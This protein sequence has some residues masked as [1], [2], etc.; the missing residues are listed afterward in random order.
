MSDTTTPHEL[1]AETLRT[2]LDAAGSP[3]YETW[4]AMTRSAGFCTHPIRLTRTGAEGHTTVFARCENRRANVCPSCSDLYAADTW[5]LVAG[6]LDDDHLNGSAAVFATL[7]APS[8]GTVHTLRADE[9]GTPRPCHSHL[10]RATVCP[11]GRPQHCTLTHRPGDLTLGRPLCP[12]CYDYASHALTTW[13][14]PQL[15]HR[16]T[17][18]LRRQIRA[19]H[20]AVRVS[21]VK[22]M[23]LQTRLAPHYHTIIRADAPDGGGTVAAE[24]LASV[25]QAAAARVH[26]D[27]PAPA[28]PLRLRFGPECDAQPI[29][30]SSTAGRAAGYLA[31]Y[32][33]KNITDAP[34]PRR[35]PKTNIGLLPV[36][37][38]HKQ[39]MHSLAD[40]AEA[41]PDHYAGMADHLPSLGWRGHTTTKSRAYSTTMGQQKAIRT[42]WRAGHRDDAADDAQPGEEW[43]YDGS[44]HRTPGQRYLALSAALAHREQLWA[45]RQLPDLQDQR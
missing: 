44:G 24:T 2:L 41:L 35:I 28:G 14:F 26:L 32:V 43:Q 17:I 37:D 20:S 5:H 10:H 21:F 25:V 6:G 16:F 18:Q 33:T 12:A 29:T 3:G 1:D 38:H 27:V 11:H 31:K 15:W 30:G 9:N 8:F 4:W 22:V 42:A 19:E 40:L 7:T 45:L 34:L 13:W 36:S 39:I 23:E